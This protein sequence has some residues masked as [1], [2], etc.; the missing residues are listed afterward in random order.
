MD[1]ITLLLLG[2]DLSAEIAEMQI[3]SNE[4]FNENIRNEDGTSKDKE[5]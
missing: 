2:L 5:H 3:Q 1:F 4:N